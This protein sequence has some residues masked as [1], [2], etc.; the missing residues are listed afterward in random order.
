MVARGSAR[1][2]FAAAVS[3]V[4]LLLLLWPEATDLLKWERD[5]LA[6]GQAW[7]WMSAHL[8]H[9]GLMHCLSNLLGLLLICGSVWDEL[10]L[11]EAFALWLWTAAGTSLLLWWCSPDIRWYV[12]LSGVLHGL[13][14]GCALAWFE[15][16]GDRLASVALVLLGIKLL[17]PLQTLNAMP[18]VTV[19]HAYGALCG[20]LWAVLRSVQRR[21]QFFG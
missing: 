21:S 20:L 16:T 4:S 8:A 2:Q 11:A 18:V 17:V 9:L 19:A 1:W 6:R 10:G 7:R 5:T 3:I 15:R 14:A 13:W 12:G